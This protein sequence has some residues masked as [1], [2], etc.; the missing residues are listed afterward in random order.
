M[1]SSRLTFSL[2]S[3][4]TLFACTLPISGHAQVMGAEPPPLPAGSHAPAFIT[5]SLQ[6]KP[7]SLAS[8]RGKVV[9]IDYWA[10]WCGPCRMATPTLEALH[11]KF[12][13]QGLRV[14]GI[15]LDRADSV[16]QVK[17]FVKAYGMTYLVSADPAL[18]G[19]AARAYHVNGIPSQYLIDKKGI[20]RWSQSGYSPAE[21]QELAGRIRMLLAEK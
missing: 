6:G 20:V 9:L 13:R 1:P 8:L 2:L 15:S 5:T 21:G 7:L 19:R 11:K 3:A 14:V 12:A 18:N 17:P 16:A 4:L 10:T